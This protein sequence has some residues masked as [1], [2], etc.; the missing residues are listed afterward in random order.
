MRFFWQRLSLRLR[1]FVSFGVL[2]A[3]TMLVSLSLQSGFYSQSRV[4]GLLQQELPTQLERLRAEIALRLAPSIQASRSLAASPFIERWIQA[5]M[6]EADL[7]LIEAEMSRVH[8]LLN[9][10]S[11]FLA[12]SDGQQTVYHHYQNGALNHRQ[13]SRDHPDDAWYFRYLATGAPYELNLDTDTFN[14]DLQLFVN[15]SSPTRNAAGTPFSVAGVGLDMHYLAEMIGAYRL[16]DTGRASLAN[17]DGVLEVHASGALIQ[18][19]GATPALRALLDPQQVRVGE[20]RHAGQDLLVGVIWIAD[21]QRYLV[22]EVPRAEFLDPIARQLGQ[23][24][25]IGVLLL[26]LSL[27]LLY[28]LTVSLSRPLVRFQQQLKHITQTLDLSQRL[29]TN[30]QSELGDLAQQTNRL[31]ERLSSTIQEIVSGSE[32]LAESASRLAQTAGLVSR[33]QLLSPSSNYSMAAA[34]EQMSAAVVEITTTMEEL[35]GASSQIAE[36]S[37]SVADAASLTLNHGQ[38]GEAAMQQLLQG[39]AEI[40]RD[41]AQNLQDISELSARSQQI[42]KVM[43]FIQTLADQTR[44]IAFNAALEAASAGEFGRRFSVVADEIRRLADS[45]T[46]SAREIEDRIQDIQ[47]TVGRLVTTSEKGANAIQASMQVSSLTADD[48]H[49][50]VGAASQTSTAARQISL[51]TRQ[52]QTASGQVVAALRDISQ[53]SAQNARS[54]REIT[55]ISEEMIDLSD[56]LNA[57]TQEFRAQE[58]PGSPGM[59][60]HGPDAG[61]D[62]PDPSIGQAS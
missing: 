12:A 9:A 3:G 35:S 29:H 14:A 38:K 16:G 57:L 46:T 44:L 34:V 54:V 5:G 28:P 8:A 17:R 25:L 48:L 7:P 42:G 49:A 21:L 31:L 43:D 53:A 51:S 15:Y 18:D 30:D 45:V 33:R 40:H 6:P 55:D 37:Q 62:T 26:A 1:L 27:L 13:M 32:R 19:L 56:S 41:T 52:Q 59:T 39:M 11:V 61:A 22:V 24:L 23:S 58:R 10:G 36:H 60:D 2:L 4:E 47:E 20:I 50:L